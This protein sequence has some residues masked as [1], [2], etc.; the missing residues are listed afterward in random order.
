MRILSCLDVDIESQYKDFKDLE[1]LY[2]RIN[3]KKGEQAELIRSCMLNVYQWFRKRV[4]VDGKI[5][6]MG[7]QYY[8]VYLERPGSITRMGSVRRESLSMTRHVYQRERQVV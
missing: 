7:G 1:S 4:G 5:V 6:S 8:R 3:N 2:A